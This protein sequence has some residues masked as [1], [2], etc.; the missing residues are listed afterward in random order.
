MI[1]WSFPAA[2]AK[3][4]FLRLDRRRVLSGERERESKTWERERERVFRGP[5][6]TAGIWGSVAR[7]E[8]AAATTHVDVVEFCKLIGKI[9]RRRR[10]EI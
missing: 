10:R 3:I 2:G 7:R 4:E 8:I 1:H 6:V 9:W 5:D